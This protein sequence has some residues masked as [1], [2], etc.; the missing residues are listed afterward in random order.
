MSLIVKSSDRAKGI[1]CFQQ[2]SYVPNQ[3]FIDT[4]AQANSTAAVVTF[5]LLIIGNSPQREEPFLMA[6]RT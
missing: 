6:M 3:R 1:N 2:M 5:K 4:I